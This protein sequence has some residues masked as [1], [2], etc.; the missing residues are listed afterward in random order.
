MTEKL[1]RIK[2]AP[3]KIRKTAKSAAAR[4]KNKDPNTVTSNRLEI[5]VT[6]VNRPKT[7][8]YVDLIQ[9]FEVNMQSIALAKGTAD[10]GTLHYLGL[11][12]TDKSVILSVIQENRIPDALGALEEKFR[13][14]KGGKGIAFTVPL[15]SVIGTLL[16]GFLSNN[17]DV[18]KEKK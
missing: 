14:V 16:F 18:I 4:I 5:L 17:K 15:T 6:V 8:Y 10:V 7:E 2:A 12:D 9:S 1:N 3:A 13:T 11:T